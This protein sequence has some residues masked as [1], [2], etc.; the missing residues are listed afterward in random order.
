MVEQ[1]PYARN[2]YQPDDY[3]FPKQTDVSQFSPQ[4]KRDVQYL[5]YLDD[6]KDNNKYSKTVLDALSRHGVEIGR[7]LYEFGKGHKHNLPSNTD[8]LILDEVVKHDD[9]HH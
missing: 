6:L 2:I 9:H 1:K 3:L 5:Q 8:W 7:D 4:Q